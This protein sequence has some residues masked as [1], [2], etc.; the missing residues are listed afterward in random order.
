MKAVIIL[1]V[2]FLSCKDT[3]HYPYNSQV[4]EDYSEHFRTLDSLTQAEVQQL[5]QQD[6]IEE[7]QNDSIYTN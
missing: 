1:A 2:L 6:S 7:V 3:I 5:Q 4:V